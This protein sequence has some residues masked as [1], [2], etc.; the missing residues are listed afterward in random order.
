M[1]KTVRLRRSRARTTNQSQKP[2]LQDC[3]GQGQGP[4]TNH[5]SRDC[6]TAQVKGKDHPPITQC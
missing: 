3:A 6:K 5:K 4:P 2:R 1:P